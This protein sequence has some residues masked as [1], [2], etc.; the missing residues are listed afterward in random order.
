MGISI[1]WII[2]ALAVFGI[3]IFVAVLGR[4][5]EIICVSY[6]CKEKWAVVIVTLL[7]FL[8]IIFTYV[9]WVWVVH[10]LIYG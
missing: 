3:I 1:E 4:L 2:S 9:I 10:L 5:I 7:S 6:A 8:P